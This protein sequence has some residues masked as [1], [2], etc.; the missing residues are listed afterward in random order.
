M[1]KHPGIMIYNVHSTCSVCCILFIAPPDPFFCPY[2]LCCLP[3]GLTWKAYI[4]GSRILWLLVGFSRRG[5]LEGDWR[6]IVLISQ[7][8]FLWGHFGVI[9]LPHCRS[10][11]LSRWFLCRSLILGFSDCSLPVSFRTTFLSYYAIS[12]FSLNESSSFPFKNT[13]LHGA[14]FIHCSRDWHRTQ[15]WPS[16]HLSSLSY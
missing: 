2:P 1:Y 6:E 13:L 9:F 7:A 16:I 3:W 10:L 12:A 4:N 15:T 11:L 14:D 5:V 8:L